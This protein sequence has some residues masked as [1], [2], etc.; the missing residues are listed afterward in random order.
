MSSIKLIDLCKYYKGLSYQ[1]AAISE[2]EEAINKAN[3]HI[4]G[5]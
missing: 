4:L 2:L 5:R 3:P 1:M